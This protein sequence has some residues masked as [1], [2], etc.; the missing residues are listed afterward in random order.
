MKPR[1]LLIEDN[2]ANRY[3]A[4]FLLG[5][6][7]AEVFIAK[8]G[9][10]GLA[11]VETTQP[12]AI[13]LDIQMPEMDGYEVA[14][15]L[16]QNPAHSQIPILVVSSYAMIGDRQRAMKLGVTDYLEK[17]Y[18]PEEFTLRVRKLV[19]SAPPP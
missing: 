7:G 17:P 1:I 8:D 18:D 10:E 13:V 5:Q 4:T 15:I 14:R 12:T 2:E 6:L 19:E 3:L 16:K 11:M 9:R